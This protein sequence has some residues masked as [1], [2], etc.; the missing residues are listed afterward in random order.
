MSR[1]DEA[2]MLHEKKIRDEIAAH[3]KRRDTM[4]ADLL[5]LE[6]DIETAELD[7]AEVSAEVTRRSIAHQ[8]AQNFVIAEGGLD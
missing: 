7:L 1:L 2:L 8:R 6:N 4:R 5:K 3:H